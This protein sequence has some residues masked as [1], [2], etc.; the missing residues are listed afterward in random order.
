MLNLEENCFLPFCEV[1]IILNIL[2]IRKILFL[3]HFYIIYHVR[4]FWRLLRIKCL[5]RLADF[6]YT[7]TDY[8]FL[9]GCHFYTKQGL[10][11]HKM[12]L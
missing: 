11:R 4:F 6:V 3:T 9:G 7:A 1:A 2:G 12:S 8:F 5:S 10:C